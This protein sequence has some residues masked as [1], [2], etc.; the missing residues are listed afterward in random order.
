MNLEI[1]LRAF[2]VYVAS[3]FLYNSEKWKK[4]NVKKV[5]ANII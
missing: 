1:K 2:S 4:V 5:T 3:I